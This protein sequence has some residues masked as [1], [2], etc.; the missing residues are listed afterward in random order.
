M[1]KA[2]LVQCT[3]SKRDE[4]VAAKDIYDESAYFC[5][6]RAYAEATGD[7][8][9][10]LSAKHGLV[11]P[12]EIVKP[13]DEIGL[14]PIQCE[15][16]AMRLNQRDIDTVEVIAGKKYTDPLTPELESYGIEVIELCRGLGIGERMARLDELVSEYQDQN[17]C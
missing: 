14:D 6:M 12:E 15:L 7:S 11:D 17:L 1:S 13:Y 4:T 3:N 8:W 9:F 16:I 2:V 10:I 5:K